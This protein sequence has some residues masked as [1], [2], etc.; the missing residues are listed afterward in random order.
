[1]KIHGKCEQIV[2]YFNCWKWT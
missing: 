1:V 2:W